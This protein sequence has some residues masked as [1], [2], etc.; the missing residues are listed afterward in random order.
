VPRAP[1][2]RAADQ[3][4]LEEELVVHTRTRTVLVVL[5]A[6]L[7]ALV[8]A[9]TALAVPPSPGHHVVEV[10]GRN[11]KTRNHFGNPAVG[12]VLCSAQGETV[13]TNG[14]GFPDA[15]RGRAACLEDHGARRVRIYFIK[16]QVFFAESWVDVAV[17][18]ADVVS[19]ANVAY[20]IT[21][22]PVPGFCADDDITLTYRV[23]QAFGI[24]WH[25]GTL[26]NDSVTSDQFEARAAVNTQ[27]C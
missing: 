12:S 8:P 10:L 27:V 16:L 25:D 3:V 11:T 21:Y 18:D 5:L 14:N 22:T 20:P 24:R 19:D 13:D 6:V 2:K 4:Q 1:Q 9:A 15:L 17:D 7:V 23:V 26:T